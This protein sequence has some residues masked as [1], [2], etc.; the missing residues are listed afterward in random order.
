MCLQLY[1]YILTEAFYVC[2]SLY[3]CSLVDINCHEDTI[4]SQELQNSLNYSSQVGGSLKG[5]NLTS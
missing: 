5:V 4:M 1:E 3:K 2:L